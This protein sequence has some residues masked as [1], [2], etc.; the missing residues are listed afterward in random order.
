MNIIANRKIFYAIS[1][2]L[3]LMSAASL[4]VWGLKPGIDFTGGSILEVDFA[5]ERPDM[6]KI[7]RNIGSLEIGN[8][9]YQPTGERGLILRFKDVTEDQ[10]QA[11]LNI[12]SEG[13]MPMEDVLVEKRFD[14]IGPIMGRELARR[15]Y[16][17]IALVSF[18]IIVFIAWVFRKV[19]RPVSSWKY[20]LS[21]VVALIHDI[22]IPTGIFAALGHFRN[23]EIDSLFVTALLTILGFSIHDT[24]V[25]FDRTRE[26]LKKG[27]GKKFEETVEISL[28]QVMGRSLKTSFAIVMVL[29]ALFF[30]GGDTTKY[31]SLAMLLGIIFGT[32]SSLFIASPLL[33]TW[34][35]FKEKSAKKRK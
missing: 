34:N 13:K 24:I 6:E 31:F 25:V 23:V 19:S 35:S 7:K 20:G 32:Y 17:A 27:L 30:F 18:M 33:V 12:L 15:A 9:V 28:K 14:S 1:I 10:H 21:A 2:S 3:V 8:V 4:F 22:T 5:T 16:V 11:I 29:S 26:N